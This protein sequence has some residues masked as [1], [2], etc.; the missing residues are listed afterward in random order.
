MNISLPIYHKTLC[1]AEK[2]KFLV[3]LL[4]K[5]LFKAALLRTIGIALNRILTYG[6]L[7][8]YIWCIRI[9]LRK[10]NKH[11]AELLHGILKVFARAFKPLL[12]AGGDLTWL[13]CYSLGICYYLGMCYS[14]SFSYGKMM[15]EGEIHRKVPQRISVRF[16]IQIQLLET[17]RKKKQ[18]YI[19]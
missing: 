19:F 2:I 9:Y 6:A 1:D 15:S 3:C 17:C 5:E 18:D 12:M 13:S 10:W 7:W 11:E 16:R 4:Y 14:L 8:P